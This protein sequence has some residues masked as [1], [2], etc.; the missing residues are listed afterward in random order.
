VNENSTPNQDFDHLR[1]LSIFHYVVAGIMGLCS[2]IPLIH[3]AIGIAII[4]GKFDEFANGAGPPVLFGWFFIIIP[5]IGIVCGIAMSVLVAIAGKQLG[6]HK[7]H[8]FCIV[9]AAIEC[10][11]MPI[12]TVL[13]VFT[14]IVLIR[15]SVKELFGVDQDSQ[16]I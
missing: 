1:L 16:R 6:R 7:G 11:F 13:G 12:G 10:M 9:V 4:S 5:L 15:P 2:L 8:T 3:V 14:I